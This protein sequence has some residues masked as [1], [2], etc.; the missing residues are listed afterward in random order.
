MRPQTRRTHTSRVR[1][2]WERVRSE[3]GLKRN[4]AV[5]AG[6]IVLAAVVGGW[7][8]GNQ[9]FTPPWENRLIVNATFE[10]TPGISPGNGQEV[11][12]AGVPVGEVRSADV[13]DNG[14]A[15]VE[16]AIEREHAVYEDAT[17]V[18]RPKSPLN[19]MYILLDPGTPGAKRLSDGDTLP[20]TASERPVQIDEVLG[21]LDDNTRHALAALVVESD[22]ALASAPA[23]L[24]AGLEKT[25][26]LLRDMKPVSESLS[27]RRDALSELVTA[28][29]QISQAVGEDDVRLA[30]LAS[31]LDRTLG[32]VGKR[33]EE[34][35]STLSQLPGLAGQL[36]Q[37]TQA[38]QKLSGQLNPT[39]DA[40]RSAAADLPGALS[41][42]SGTAD[43]LGSTMDVLGPLAENARPVVDDL[44][45]F[46]ADAT[47]T[48]RSVKRFSPLIDPVTSTLV[49][50]TRDV[51]AFVLNTRSLTTLAD[52]NGGITR[53]QLTFG[54]NG[55]PIK[56]HSSEEG[57]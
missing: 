27:K 56:D 12:I 46:T 13:D 35:D 47:R 19:E 31:A 42:L 40:V 30:K 57:R 23:R 29:G 1:R 21:Y 39:L 15:V 48:V 50:H 26:A 11:R 38:V 45:P 6:L 2:T 8:L 44:R 55:L 3:P 17:V 52:A 22:A 54:V 5:L 37:S 36:K 34:L 14:N 53:A 20:V 16:M 49:K 25:T 33:N 28:L 4:L 24:P 43:R 7:I 18:L 10:G 9:R 51:G 32:T 41:K